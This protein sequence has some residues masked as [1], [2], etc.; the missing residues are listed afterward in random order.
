MPRRIQLTAAPASRWKSPEI[1]DRPIAN[2]VVRLYIARRGFHPPR[3]MM[4]PTVRSGLVVSWCGMRG[5]VTLAAAFAL[6]E[7]APDG[8][9]AFP[10]RDLIV[11]TAFCVVLGTLVLQGLT[12]RSI[13]RRAQLAD[14]DPVGR[15]TA[16]AR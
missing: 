12:L 13:L 6:P 1:L 4:Q 11:F 16:L 2:T 14:D 8:Q 15:E 5:I 10:F 7:A 3:P 9:G